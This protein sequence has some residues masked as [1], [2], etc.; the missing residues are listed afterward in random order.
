[1]ARKLRGVPDAALYADLGA[2]Y[3]DHKQFSCAAEVFGKAAALQPDSARYQYLLGLSL[4]SSKRSGDAIDPLR[5]AL[6]IQPEFLDAHM[7]LAAALD[8][9]DNRAAAEAQWRLA[10]AVDPHSTLALDSLSRDLLAD[11]NYSDV[12][13][14]LG[15]LAAA[16]NLT[17]GLAV[18]L[19]AAYSQSGLLQESAETLQRRLQVS[20]SSLPVAEALS[21][22]LM[23][24]S[25]FQD[26]VE[27]LA[28][29]AKQNPADM[30]AQ[31][32]YLQTLVLAHDAGAEK[33]GE[34]LLA[35]SPRNWELLYFMGILH[36]QGNDDA[37]AQSF[38]RRSIAAKPDNADAH[39]RLAMVLTALKQ[40]S[41]AKEQL[42]RAAQLGLDSP[43]LHVA[44]AKTLQSLGDTA[45][46]Q[47]QFQLYA[48][49]LQ[50]Q[51]AR[52]QA[53]NKAQQ[54]DQA[55]AAGNPQQTVQD[56]RE[57]LALDP[58]EPVLAYKLAMA[59]D[60]M[61][62]HAGERTA[63]NQ[64]IAIDPHMAL[65]QNQLGYLDASEGNTSAAIQHFQLAAQADPGFLKSWLNLAASLCLDSRWAEAREAVNH[66]LEL[67]AGN[68]SAK[69]LL[70]QMD[71]MQAQR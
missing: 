18:D 7:T 30:R 46:A 34:R 38:L 43:E 51:T 21:G 55:Q 36:Q 41:A 54:G 68:A 35:S 13:A 65:A 32:L 69:A 3:A 71:A 44:L 24:Q 58:K 61:G 14:L 49:R 59:L 23:L 70:Q 1:M 6:R 45:A 40:S 57:A 29:I 2:W 66:V 37:G 12:I 9:R 17:D 52:A 56:Y 16:G 47:H 25:R 64:A 63:L 67:D 26:A 22:V 39:Y 62:D 20:P 60:K 15:P 31:V 33:V 5:R 10:L 48:Q 4:Y 11:R 50:E 53:A 28:P 27:V 8:A 42:Q 19:S